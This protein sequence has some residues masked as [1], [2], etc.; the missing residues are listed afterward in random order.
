MTLAQNR[1]KLAL[2]VYNYSVLDHLDRPLE[3]RINMQMRARSAEVLYQARP[4]D[5]FEP[6]FKGQY[7]APS[8]YPYPLL[9]EPQKDYIQIRAQTPMIELQ[10]TWEQII[11]PHF[12]ESGAMFEAYAGGRLRSYLTSWDPIK[13]ENQNP[14]YIAERKARHKEILQRVNRTWAEALTQL[15]QKHRGQFIFYR[16]DNRKMCE[17]FEDILSKIPSPDFLTFKIANNH[18]RA[19][20]FK[21]AH[22][23]YF[24]HKEHAQSLNTALYTTEK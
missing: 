20:Q 15:L 1:K 21:N 11:L 24:V 18:R 4:E 17:A 3:Y 23:F 5:F 6:I 12:A 22:D 14:A 7:S 9:I 13:Q 2:K 16:A 8:I 19:Q 10:A